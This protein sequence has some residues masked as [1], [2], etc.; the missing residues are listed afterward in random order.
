MTSRMD[1][2]GRLRT[3][4]DQAGNEI[5][6]FRVEVDRPKVFAIVVAVLEK[7]AG[8]Q[9]NRRRILEGTS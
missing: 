8:Q 3:D 4:A 9:R 5:V 1:E 6:V 7:V 2:R